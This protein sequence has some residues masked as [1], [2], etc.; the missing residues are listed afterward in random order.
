MTHVKAP[1]YQ[2]QKPE[3]LWVTFVI[4]FVFIAS[5]NPWI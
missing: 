2:R 4:I 5:E 1:K 3:E